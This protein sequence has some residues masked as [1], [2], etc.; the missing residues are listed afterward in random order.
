MF[1]IRTPLKLWDFAIPK[2]W[3]K[4]I[5]WYKSY[6]SIRRY[7]YIQRF[8]K[9][10]PSHT[11]LSFLNWHS[12]KES[13][14]LI[15]IHSPNFLFNSSIKGFASAASFNTDPKSLNHPT[16][17]GFVPEGRMQNSSSG[18]FTGYLCVEL[19]AY[20]DLEFHTTHLNLPMSFK[21][22]IIIDIRIRKIPGWDWSTSNTTLQLFP[23]STALVGAYPSSSL[24]LQKAH[25][26]FKKNWIVCCMYNIGLISSL[27]IISTFR[28]FV[29]AIRVFG[30][31]TNDSS[32]HW[33][34]IG[35]VTN[36][37]CFYIILLCLGRFFQPHCNCFSLNYP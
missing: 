1:R 2:H 32:T 31:H 6:G 33:W 28:A 16:L 5:V 19:I 11:S 10:H 24:H 13:I 8:C 18:P 37:I 15:T 27:T 25:N 35:V 7:V 30:I 12:K 9:K 21:N 3:S 14:V 4:F 20:I 34:I 23:K 29:E 17:G 36:V 22:I 26:S